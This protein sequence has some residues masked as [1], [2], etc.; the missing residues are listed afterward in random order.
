MVLSPLGA[1][2]DRSSGVVYGLAA[3]YVIGG[4]AC[5]IWALALASRS[6][7]RKEE[8]NLSRAISTG[9]RAWVNDLFQVVNLRPDLFILNAYVTTAATGVYS[10]ALSITSA[11]FILSQSLA[12]VVLPRSAA[13]HGSR[14]E[15]GILVEERTAASAVRHAVLVSFAAALALAVL[16][17]AVPAIWGADFGRTTEYGLIMLPGVI[18]LGIGRVMV[19]AFTGRGHPHFALA[20]GLLSFPATL[21]AYLLVIP[22]YG[23]V[24]AAIVSSASYTAAALL[25]GVLFFSTVKMPVRELLVPTR[26][27]AADY[28]R[29]ADRLRSRGAARP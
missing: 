6:S 25:A 21:V 2:I 27:D 1:V 22:E 8:P 19:A 24:G 16:L 17:L 12:T 3:G 14:S 26:A 11:G 15:G 5:A 7:P 10:V 29:F 28:K 23:T 18:L 20:V 9:L 13:L 4:S